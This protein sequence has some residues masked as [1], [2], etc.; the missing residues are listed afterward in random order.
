MF[1]RSACT[2]YSWQKLLNNYKKKKTKTADLIQTKKQADSSISY[3]KINKL[4]AFQVLED[5]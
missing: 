3:P 5:G 4:T 2:R 1:L